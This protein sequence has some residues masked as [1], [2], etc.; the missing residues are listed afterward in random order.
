MK[1]I[2]LFIEILFLLLVC[3]PVFI[4]A[5]IIIETSFIFYYLFK[6]LKKWKTTT[7][8]RFRPR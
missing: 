3:L 2:K 4:L 5:Y 6:Q 8:Q 7:C 1:L